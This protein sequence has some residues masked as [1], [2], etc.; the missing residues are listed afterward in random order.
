MMPARYETI[1]GWVNEFGWTLGAEIGVSDGKTH[2][3]L[4]QHCPGL[5]LVGVD[6]WDL[7]GIQPGATFSGERCSCEYCSETRAG[8]RA[9]TVQER[10]RMARTA[11][12]TGRSKL[13]KMTSVKAAGK[14]ADG[15]LDFVFVDGDHA[16]EGV[17]SDIR[18]W[19]PKIKR[20]GRLIGHDAN[21]RSVADGIAEHFDTV[22]LGD[23]HIWW[24][25]I[26]G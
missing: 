10:E 8:R 21:M 2:R 26:R 4:L 7:P 19:L 5:K 18:T 15:S 11:E 17:S 12:R 20:G 25:D 22:N 13:Y 14:I 1:A 24:I 3:Y 6:V 23:D 16:Q 9:T